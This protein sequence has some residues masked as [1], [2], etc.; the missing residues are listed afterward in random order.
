MRCYFVAFSGLSEDSR[1]GM[2]A[3][4]INAKLG[5]VNWGLSRPPF[6]WVAKPFIAFGASVSHS[7]ED[8]NLIA[9]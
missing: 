7:G 5:G 8:V 2:Q 3:M 9:V 1:V 6:P 4:K